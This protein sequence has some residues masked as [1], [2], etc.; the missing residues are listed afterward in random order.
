MNSFKRLF[1][2]MV[3]ILMVSYLVLG[4]AFIFLSYHYTVSEKTASMQEHASFV[5]KIAGEGYTEP[6]G[7]ET[8][9]EGNDA[10]GEGFTAGISALVT[11][12]EENVLVCGVDGTV[13]TS[14]PTD[15]TSAETDTQLP[16]EFVSEVLENGSYDGETDLGLFEKKNLVVAQP[17]YSGENSEPVG[18]AV[19]ASRVSNF[20]GLW[21]KMAYLFLGSAVVVLCVSAV[22]CWFISRQSVRPL[23]EIAGVVR[24]FGHGEYELRAEEQYTARKDEVG[25]LARAFNSMADSIAT[26]EQQRQEFI[27]NI[28]HEL[29][30]PMTTIQGF[31][32]GILDGTITG[33]KEKDALRV[34]SDETRR[35]SR[36]VRRMLNASRLAAQAQDGTVR[37]QSKFELNETIARVIISLE[38][39]ITQRGLDMD[40]QLPEE[41][42]QV[43]GDM[44][45]I[46]QVCYNLLDN[47]AKFATPGS[48]IKVSV[49]QKGGKEYISVSNHGNTIPPEELPL[50][51]DRF[52]KLDQ[53]RSLD[54][55]GV[56]LGL[57]I[58]KTILNGIQENITVTSVDGLTTFTFTLT[59][60]E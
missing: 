15:G 22:T 10:F 11:L 7:A 45:S 52:H 47:A 21:Q 13:W 50:V 4:T 56:G 55:D 37:P 3:S 34:I 6:S 41:S 5:A 35:L 14:Y 46:T 54:K 29:K 32:D 49:T 26:T 43:W 30:T 36:L 27:S 17:I 16:A 48:T 9:D 12:E 1:L 18:L 28:S 53:S 59:R 33:A 25:E 20:E 58:V 39:K 40:V 44:D 24:R 19:V 42:V 57:Y 31:A 2:A 23:N 51:F 8:Q 60:A 38:R